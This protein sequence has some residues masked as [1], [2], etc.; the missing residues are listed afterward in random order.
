MMAAMKT[1]SFFAEIFLRVREGLGWHPSQANGAADGV[2]PPTA[3]QVRRARAAMK[4]ARARRLGV[5]MPNEEIV[6]FVNA[7]RRW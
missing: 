6:A 5:T 3:E 1:E 4:R 7:G 2:P